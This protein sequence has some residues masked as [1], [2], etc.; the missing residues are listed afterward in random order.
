MQSL[1]RACLKL[2][3]AY[4]LL[5]YLLLHKL[6]TMISYRLNGSFIIR[7]ML[8]VHLQLSSMML[9]W[10]HR[11]VNSIYTNLNEHFEQNTLNLYDF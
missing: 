5:S 11:I 1:N 10:L 4:K 6:Y 7:D 8:L 2:T 3:W 9:M